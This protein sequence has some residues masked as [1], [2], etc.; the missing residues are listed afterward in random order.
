MR[1]MAVVTS[2]ISGVVLVLGLVEWLT[3]FQW[4]QGD[5]DPLFGDPHILLNDGATALIA[6]GF[7]GVG[8]IIMWVLARRKDQGT[9][10]RR[11]GDQ[12]PS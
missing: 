4:A 5:Q 7:L 3:N 12:R 11:Q 2:V 9:A 6:A 8:S 1:R 10:G